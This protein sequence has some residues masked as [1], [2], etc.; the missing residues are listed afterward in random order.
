MI[1]A[2]LLPDFPLT[3]KIAFTAFA[4]FI[5]PV[6]YKN[7]GPAN[8]LWFSDI[9]LFLSVAALWYKSS[10]LFS[11]IAVGVLLPEIG[12]NIDYFFRLLTGKKLIGLS[13]YMFEKSKS[14]FLRGL[15]IFHIL[16][17][18]L[19]IWGMMLYGYNEKALYYQTALAFIVLPLSRWFGKPEENINWVYGLGANPQ[20]KIN[21][22]LY[23]I[24]IVIAFPLFVYIPSHFIL[25]YFF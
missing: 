4:L 10:L 24:L 6:Y 15:S 19:L 9:S 7:W 22:R 16:L 21:S 2:N 14:L 11:M 3:F 8:F 25:K 12:W 13:D 23:F 5:I 20:K 18:P 17:P 1:I